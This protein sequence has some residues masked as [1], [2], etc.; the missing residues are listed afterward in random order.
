MYLKSV[1][2]SNFRQFGTVNKS[3]P[4]ITV[5]FN[6]NFN[7][8]VG[9][10]DSGKTA[11]IDAI[12][13]LLGSISDDIE[14]I[15]LEDFYRESIGTHSDSF[16]IEGT[17]SDLTDKEAG[18]FLEWLSF[19]NE[20]EYELRVS[21]RVEKKINENGQ[22]Y[23]ERKVQAGEKIYESRLR[24][25][26]KEFL[27]TT[28]LKPLRDASNELKPGFRSRLAHILKA[29]PAFKE[30]NDVEH[31]LV[32]TIQEANKKVED[33]F[34]EEYKDGRSLVR[35]LELLLSDFHDVNDQSKSRSKFSVSQ[36]DL[37]SIL[38]RLSLDTEDINLGLGNLNLLFIATELLLLK[39]NSEENVIGPQITL[40]EEIEAHLHTQ[41]QIRLI[42]YLEEELGRSK[43]RNQYI[44]TS[45]STNL[46]ASIDPRSI[47][48]MHNRVAYP[49]REEYTKLEHE[50]YAFL[51][52][53][54]DSTKSN[55]FFAK[56][57]IF[58]EGDSEM[59]LLPA[60][61]NLLGYPLHKSGVSLVNV[62]GTS[63][64]R[65]IKLFSRSDLWKEPLDRP[66][67]KTPISIITDID[68]KPMVYYNIEG[69]TK[70]VYSIVD[71]SQLT[72]VLN[73]CDEQYDEVIPEH[74]GIEYS[75]LNKLSSDF[76][77]TLTEG[78]R[79]EIEKRVKKSIS[80]QY[81]ISSGLQKETSLM[82]KYSNYDANLEVCISPDWTL[83]YSLAL[84][85]LAP[86]LLES[87]QEVRYKKPFEGKKNEVFKTLKEKLIKTP[88]D[89]KLAYQVFK[90]INDK[91]VSKA[92][93]AQCLAIKLNA[94]ADDP[95]IQMEMKEQI[96]KDDKL[97]YI[98]RAIVHSSTIPNVLEEVK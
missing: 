23:I 87:I 20:D 6:P 68:V 41:A 16:Y 17:F 45:H 70:A 4:A 89:P 30:S 71:H 48:F 9:E 42:K 31:S 49:L 65:Y 93:V 90:P 8:L 78:N 55:L 92:E 98:V 53:F 76:G 62:N 50:D 36:T 88:K 47:I 82:D 51:Q 84:S 57:I 3:E 91:L 67:I 40:I 52:R 2:L 35:D 11:I 12:R 22:E 27:K 85:C 13:Y 63:F 81:I 97:N 61:A 79:P 1:S 83:E 15:K 38:K 69:K 77:I 33:F 58:V 25:Q 26:A 21:L 43:K 54:L 34:Q 72:D 59:L 86:L 46:V 74:I 66:A 7:I 80:E 39:N 19:N 64:E 95:E 32:T 18:A 96:F 24:S 28:Y 37:T 44:L 56:G 10:N 94:V 14:K 75:T 29:H 60:L 5:E 73:L